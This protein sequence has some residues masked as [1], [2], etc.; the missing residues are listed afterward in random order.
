MGSLMERAVNLVTSIAL[1]AWH[2][3]GLERRGEGRFPNE[4]AI[5]QEDEIQGQ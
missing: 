2:L 1:V 3:A 4:S 5:L